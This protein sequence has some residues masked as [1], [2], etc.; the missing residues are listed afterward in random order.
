M[1]SIWEQ[2]QGSKDAKESAQAYFRFVQYLH[3]GSQRSVSA[4]AKLLGV[5]PQAIWQIAKRFNWEKRALAFD[6]ARRKGKAELPAFEPPSAPDP[7][8]PRL[9]GLPGAG[10]S[11]RHRVVV[12]EVLPQHDPEAVS[13]TGDHLAVLR[14]YQALYEELGRLMAE[15]ARDCFPLVRA[16][17]QDI[18]AARNAW[19]QLIDQNEVQLSQVLCLQLQQLI[20]LYCRLSEAMHGHANGG[21][22]HWGDA[23]GVHGIL[24]EAYAAQQRREKG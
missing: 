10:A 16:F 2:G 19:R 15:E 3:L 4:V 21:R 18:D 14:R 23:I 5:T 9:G 12:P 13:L 6:K 8:P 11:K 7:E 17:R 20:P 22:Q 1:A 24:Q